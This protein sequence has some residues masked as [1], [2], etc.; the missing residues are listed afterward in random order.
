MGNPSAVA[1]GD[2]VLAKWGNDVISRLIPVYADTAARDTAHPNPTDGQLAVAGKELAIVDDGKW[3]TIVSTH[4]GVNYGSALHAGPAEVDGLL[5]RLRTEPVGGRLYEWRR[6]ATFGELS[7]IG[8]QSDGTETEAIRVRDHGSVE[9]G[10]PVGIG[11]S[12]SAARPAAGEPLVTLYTESATGRRFAFKRAAQY[13]ALD[14]V[15]I[16]AD[17]TEHIVVT[18]TDDGKLRFPG[19]ASGTAGSGT[20]IGVTAGGDVTKLSS[21]RRYKQDIADYRAPAELPVALKRWRYAAE[22]ADVGDLA[23]YHVGPIAEDVHDAGMTEFVN[24]DAD[25]RPES[26]ESA[27]LAMAHTAHLEARVATLE[28]R[29]AALEAN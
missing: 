21:S 12:T 25:G 14:M 23:P 5:L 1:A 17:G 6:A 16:Q 9:F 8:I 27:A 4:P 18:L 2:D 26:L 24:Y 7:L 22:V 11:S 13:G 10:G 19:V 20:A 15:G 28:A 3:M 29:I